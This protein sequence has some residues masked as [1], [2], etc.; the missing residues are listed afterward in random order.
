MKKIIFTPILILQSIF[1]YCQIIDGIGGIRL[2]MTT[3]EVAKVLGKK[4]LK[5][6]DK[7]KYELTPT[8]E[9][10]N[11]VPV[12]GY[13]IK[14][15]KLTFFRDSLYRMSNSS[16]FMDGQTNIGDALTIKYGEPRK[17]VKSYD[18]SYRNQYGVVINSGGYWT[19]YTWN[20]GS[21]D[22]KCTL[23][24]KGSSEYRI[25]SGDFEL[26][27]QHIANRIWEYRKEL[28]KK[29]KEKD[30]IRNEERKKELDGL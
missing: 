28:E 22:I 24:S 23:E 29:W 2:G 15:L 4:T 3:T 26:I 10:S 6:K 5:F 30:K 11:Y 1:S 18:S 16:G 7:Y 25:P 8:Y 12:K 9:I 14:S 19:V 17:E 21:P 27:N 20:T 13:Y